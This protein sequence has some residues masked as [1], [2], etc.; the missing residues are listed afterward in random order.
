[1]GRLRLD[2][3]FQHRQHVTVIGVHLVDDEHLA[4]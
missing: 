4:P 1:M 3:F 2:K